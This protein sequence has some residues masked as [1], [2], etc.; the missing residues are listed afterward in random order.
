MGEWRR[1][2]KLVEFRE[3]FYK[4]GLNQVF[5]RRATRQMGPNDLGHQ[6]RQMNQQLAGGVLITI[7]N[8]HQARCHIQF[9]WIP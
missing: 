7:P 4:N 3:H 8:S 2:A 6:R 1:T 9:S 5:L